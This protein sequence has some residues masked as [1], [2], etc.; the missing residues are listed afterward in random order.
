[1][2]AGTLLTPSV[3]K[4]QAMNSKKEQD[5]DQEEGGDMAELLIS[6]IRRD[7]HLFFRPS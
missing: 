7:R 2:V 6:G 5:E 1:M 4:Q 3:E